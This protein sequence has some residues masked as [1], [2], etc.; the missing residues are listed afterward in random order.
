MSDTSDPLNSAPPPDLW[1][2]LQP[3][4][5]SPL[6]PPI[7]IAPSGDDELV[8]TVRLRVADRAVLDELAGPALTSLPGRLYAAV[9]DLLV[10]G[11]LDLAGLDIA[12]P[13][14]RPA[15]APGTVTHE[16]EAPDAPPG[17]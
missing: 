17:R 12:L 5:L 8:I 15:G 11:D 14:F 16:F 10:P 1:R 7:E 9:K 4:R 2:K 6:L 3:P 13:D